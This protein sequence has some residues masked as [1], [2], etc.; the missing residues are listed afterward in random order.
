MS[1]PL[2]S[3]IIVGGGLAGC[4]S[5]IA[6]N[7]LR[8]DL[9]ILLLESGET[10]GGNH[11]WSFF[12][13]DVATE[14]RWLVEPFVEQVWSSYDIRFPARKRTIAT[15]YSSASSALLDR[16]VRQILRPDQY[17]LG[18]SVER[19]TPEEV[20]LTNNEVIRACA[21][22]DA[23][24]FSCLPQGQRDALDLAW[25]KFVGR[26]YRVEDG[27]GL[28]RPIVM[29]ST[30]DQIDGYRFVYSLPFD[31]E[32][33]LVED[34]YYSESDRL[35]VGEIGARL[36][37]YLQSRNWRSA[38]VER[39]EK[40]VLPVALGGDFELFWPVGD[41]GRIGVMGGFFH[42]TTGYSLPDAVRTAAF[43]ARQ[44]DFAGETL[45]RALRGEAK[46]IWRERSFY[47]LLNKMLFR[48][49]APD[50]RYR[51][52]EHFYRLDAGLIGRFYAGR[53]RLWDKI[54]ILSGKPPVPISRALAALV[55]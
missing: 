2:P 1:G 36:D 6:L 20:E 10:F 37:S 27:H 47:R 42:P 50:Q 43:L 21:V 54:R 26:E 5:A 31:G 33:L 51:V 44:S 25:Q 53:L 12:D 9:P 35:D 29:D 7:R 45:A 48:A 13:P 19:V 17:R 38:E 28:E 52:L 40:G 16:H 23:R 15:G 34:T 39:E 49:A 22:I 14:H 32:R 18:V 8:P 4:L 46:R 41:V 55:R 30:V 11:L 24:G 3:L